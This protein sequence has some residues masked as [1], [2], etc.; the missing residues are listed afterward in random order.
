MSN[1]GSKVRR[2]RFGDLG[3]HFE[4]NI[5][6]FRGKICYFESNIC[7]FESKVGGEVFGAFAS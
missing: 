2:G 1:V 4:S 3:C 7:D 6:D 5:C